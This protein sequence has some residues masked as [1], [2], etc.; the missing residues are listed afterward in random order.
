MKSLIIPLLA[1]SLVTVTAEASRNRNREVRQQARIGQGVKSGEL[2][3]KEAKKLRKG[4]K[5]IDRLQQQA[6]ADG[7][8][9]PEEK[10][11]LEKAQDRQSRRIHR[12]KTDRQQRGENNPNAPAAPPADSNGENA[13]TN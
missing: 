1:L 4:Q 10:M 6:Q 8:I 7:V 3:R 2:T 13:E 5:K 9:T 11:R 12:Q